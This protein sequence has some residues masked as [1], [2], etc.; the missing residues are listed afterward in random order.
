MLIFFLPISAGFLL[1]P[2]TLPYTIFLQWV[3]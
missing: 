3:N 2:P 1:A